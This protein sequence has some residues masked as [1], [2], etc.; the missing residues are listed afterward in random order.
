MLVT[1][2]R[3]L[4]R[5]HAQF[6]RQV[7]TRYLIKTF[8]AVARYTAILSSA[9]L[10]AHVKQAIIK[11]VMG[12]QCLAMSALPTVNLNQDRALAHASRAIYQLATDQH[13]PVLLVQTAKHIRAFQFSLN[14]T[15]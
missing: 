2:L 3:L 14:S 12:P 8:A 4:R 10:R 9:R 13:S 6:A 1:A 11:M 7:N 15:N 5:F